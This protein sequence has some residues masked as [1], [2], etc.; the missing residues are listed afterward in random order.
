MMQIIIKINQCVLIKTFLFLSCV[1][2]THTVLAQSHGNASSNQVIQQSL[3]TATKQY[4][5]TVC[6]SGDSKAACLTAKSKAVAHG[7]KANQLSTLGTQQQQHANALHAQLADYVTRH[8][9]MASDISLITN[10]VH[11]AAKLTQAA[12]H[13]HTLAALSLLSCASSLNQASKVSK[14]VP[15]K[16]TN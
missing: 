5:T 14:C 15:K 16:R 9:N 6:Q 12:A 13:A 10:Q 3:V 8:P 11:S 1:F 2:L 4:N 7:Q